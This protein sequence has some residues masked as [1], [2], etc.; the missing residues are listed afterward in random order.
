MTVEVL[1][2]RPDG[3]QVIE[4]RELPDNWFDP[5]PESEAEETTKTD[6]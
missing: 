3:T 4:T 6:E 2:C 1:V 5:A